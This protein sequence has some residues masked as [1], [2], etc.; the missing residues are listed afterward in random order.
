MKF[1]EPVLGVARHDAKVGKVF[2][3]NLF[4][5]FRSR[6]LRAALVCVFVF[7]A[8]LRVRVRLFACGWVGGSVYEPLRH[9]FPHFYRQFCFLIRSSRWEE[10]AGSHCTAGAAPG[11]RKQKKKQDLAEGVVRI[12]PSVFI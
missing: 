9:R 7:S 12:F 8:P 11:K 2:F 5:C 1:S 3:L 10:S 6:L 4:F